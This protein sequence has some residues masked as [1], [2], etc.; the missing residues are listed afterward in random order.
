M[1]DGSP[2]PTEP[3]PSFEEDELRHLRHVVEAQRRQLQAL[4]VSHGALEVRLQDR[5]RVDRAWSLTQITNAL[6]MMVAYVDPQQRY[7]FVNDRYEALWGVPRE[8]IIGR[9]VG[10]LVGDEAHSRIKGHIEEAMAGEHVEFEVDLPFGDEKRHTL[11]NY[12]PYWDEDGEVQGFY[13]TVTDITHRHHTALALERAR[14][15]EARASR[16][17]SDFL[18]N[19]S[20]E[21]RTP[22]TAILGF[23]DLLAPAIDGDDA[24]R[25]LATIRRNGR[26]LLSIVDDVLDLSNIEA[27]TVEAREERF[28]LSEVVWDVYES[29]Q[30]HATDKSIAYRLELP[31]ALPEPIVGDPLRLRQILFNLLNNAFKFTDEGHITLRVDWAPDSSEVTLVVSDSGI[32]FPAEAA[33][34]IFKPFHQHDG[35]G[36]RRHQGSG[37]GLAISAR[38]AQMMGGE[39]E[40]S[41]TPGEGSTFSVRMPLVAVAG[42]KLESTARR[43]GR[44]ASPEARRLNGRILIV[45]DNDDIRELVAVHL[46]DAGASTLAARGAHEALA[47]V[48][49]EPPDMILMDIQMP[50][51]DGLAATRK[52]RREGYTR[53]IVALTARALRHDRAEC[54]DAG[55]DDFLPKPIHF[56]DLERTVARLLEDAPP[57]DVLSRPRRVLVV[58][59]DEDNAE[60]LQLGLSSRGM[61]TRVAHTVREALDA[62]DEERPDVIVADLNLGARDSGFDILESL[63]EDMIRPR[64][65]ALSGAGELKER[66]LDAGFDAFALKPCSIERLLQLLAG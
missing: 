54:L 53:P 58:E 65:V 10:E 14:K 44:F 34:E 35:S 21:I 41:S 3:P 4:R 30:I 31:E 15:V 26:H 50:V 46:R 59:D 7:Q 49:R 43:E 2:T 5:D 11:V 28:R 39:L 61:D 17:K 13:V 48:A 32:G 63:S 40:A 56:G 29:F 20:H 22:L 33:R 51:M 66:A 47:L 52:L 27:G 64:L 12:V 25:F 62:V 9:T 55:C 16:A 6:P 37:L 42:T 36:T 24:N 57:S 1:R 18:A 19:V 45:D 60:L 23:A 38:L 8:A